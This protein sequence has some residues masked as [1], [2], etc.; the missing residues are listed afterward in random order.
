VTYIEAPNVYDDRTSTKP[1][2]FLAGGITGCWDWQAK[3]TRALE[4]LE[5]VIL[6]PRR[7]QFPM[8][9]PSAARGQIE[10][11]YDHLNKATA[12]MFWFAEEATQPI[13]LLELG[14]WS[15]SNK[16]LFVGVDD[17]YPRRE[18]IRI[19]LGLARP[20]LPIYR[21]L[22]DVTGAI[23]NSLEEI[24]ARVNSSEALPWHTSHRVGA[25]VGR[26]V[27]ERNRIKAERD[28]LAIQLKTA[29][30]DRHHLMARLGTAERQLKA[31][32]ARP[33]PVRK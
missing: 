30:D 2:I 19:Q 33:L 31:A 24:G 22:G 11:E 20:D 18:D 29:R 4:G 26:L 21:K 23:R 5:L 7:A 13:A 32:L 1:S 10:W 9:D 14:S 15:R 16:L 8:G 27:A 28:G 17:H 25:E 3:A 12:I 6:N